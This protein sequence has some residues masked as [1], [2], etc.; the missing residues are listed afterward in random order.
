VPFDSFS[1]RIR[2]HPHIAVWPPER[3][4]ILAVKDQLLVCFTHDDRK[5][6]RR[7]E[8]A[9]KKD[10]IDATPLTTVFA[11]VSPPVKQDA[12]IYQLTF[13]KQSRYSNVFQL[14]KALRV[15]AD[16]RQISPNHVLVPAPLDDHSCPSGPP[17]P[18]PRPR[19]RIRHPSALRATGPNVTVLDSGYAW[20]GAPSSNPLG[21]LPLRPAQTLNVPRDRPTAA[22]W[23][24]PIPDRFTVPATSRLSALTG[25]ANFIAGVIARFAPRAKVSFVNHN[26]G[27]DPTADDF[28]TEAGVVRSL[29]QSAADPDRLP[30]VI[31]LGF[32]FRTYG[33]QISC[34]W[35]VA[36]VRVGS[37]TPVVVPAGNQ[38]SER[39]R[40]PAALRLLGHDNVIGV[41][42][43]VNG[44]KSRFSNYGPW[45]A[46]SAKGERAQSNF[47]IVRT[48]PEDADRDSPPLDFRGWAFWDGTSFAT[49]RVVAAIAKR[50][51]PDRDGM[52]VWH[53][54]TYG[55]DP[56]HLDSHGHHLGFVLDRVV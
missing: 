27:F 37:T 47:L 35:D 2:N 20:F 1:E 43:S 51:G 38:D 52:Q 4:D 19:G 18:S 3:R 26:G 55:R 36:L 25:H 54:L 48:V 21:A 22:R 17:K 33:D 12:M 42:S 49:P 56:H 31:D 46:C 14:T 16:G 41:A 32:A 30:E 23:G 28:P 15:L 13:R 6:L 5:L 40:Y 39:Q 29:Y 10:N 8:A 11:G 7:V 45:V 9:L 34:V 50:I 53:D 24:S 44:T